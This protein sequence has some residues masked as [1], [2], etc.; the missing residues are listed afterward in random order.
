MPKFEYK[1]SDLQGEIR[2]GEIEAVTQQEATKALAKQQLFVVE[3]RQLPDIAK[4]PSAPVKLKK[5]V[6][7]PST[8][9]RTGPR[10]RFNHRLTLLQRT[11]YLRQLQVMFSAGIPLH[12]ST[13][14]LCA[15][16]EAKLQEQLQSIPKDLLKGRPLSR[17][18]E[19]SGLFNH[20]IVSAIKVGEESGSLDIILSTLADGEESRLKIGR[21]IASQLTYP[22][23][24]LILLVLGVVFLAHL[25]AGV[26]QTVVSQ[27]SLALK[28]MTILT[29]PYLIPGCA[30]GLFCAWRAAKLYLKE[31]KRKTK[32]EKLLLSL[33]SVGRFITCH[34][35]HVLTGNL[36]LLIKAGLPINRCLGLCSDLVRTEHFRDLLSHARQAI[37]EGS[38][39]SEALAWDNLIDRDVI[40]LISCGEQSGKAESSLEKISE[41]CSETL[42]SELS[43]LVSLLEPLMIAGL[44]LILGTLLMITFSPVIT[45]MSK[46]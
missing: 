14:V 23:T 9:L 32:I 29:S 40:S 4:I 3:I 39:L 20:L 17:A 42:D 37:T 22:L 21:S 12:Q 38:T 31:P 11:L 19:R 45:A 27:D 26:I 7:R 34:E 15:S 10:R 33:P 41:Y 46:L 43:S 8:P 36:A 5:P 44:G 16:L 6:D 13:S 28:L 18:F 30:L 1:A 2:D 24:V 25:M 35:T